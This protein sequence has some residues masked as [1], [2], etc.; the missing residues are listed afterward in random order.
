MMQA[1]DLRDGDHLS[2]PAW[3]DRPRVR[4]IL[5]DRQMH[6]SALAG[7]RLYWRRRLKSGWPAIGA[8]DAISVDPNQADR[9]TI[10][11]FSD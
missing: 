7:L 9:E 3:H 5:V 11:A 2:D 6:S 4:T 1:A 8:G 10:R